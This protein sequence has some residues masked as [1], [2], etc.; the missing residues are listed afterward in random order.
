MVG[1]GDPEEI[2][3]AAEAFMTGKLRGLPAV[4]RLES[5]LTLKTIKADG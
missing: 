4:L 5:H 2:V 3:G 1:H